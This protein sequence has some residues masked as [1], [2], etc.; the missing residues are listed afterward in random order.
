M[1]ELSQG[2]HHQRIVRFGECDPAGVTYYPVY[3]DW[4]HQA[5]EACFE[6]RL[7]TPYAEMIETVGFPA[8]RTS[9]SFRKP[10]PVGEHITLVVTVAEMGK[11]SIV[12]RFHVL[13]RAGEVATV[14]EVKTVCIAVDTEGFQFA[15][16][17][18]PEAVRVGLTPIIESH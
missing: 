14:G 16:V 9:A 13:N 7:Q 17:P 4:F 10:L 1:S 2:F 8:V 3:F 12:W 18:I 15:S 11:S 5:M 6:E